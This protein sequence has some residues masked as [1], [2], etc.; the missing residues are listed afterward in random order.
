MKEFYV[1]GLFRKTPIKCIND[2]LTFYG[3]PRVLDQIADSGFVTISAK[4]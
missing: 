1:S 4:I 2:T 3:R